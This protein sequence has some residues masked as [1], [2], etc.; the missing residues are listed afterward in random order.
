MD[1]I[2]CNDQ[3]L[4]EVSH[5]ALGRCSVNMQSRLRMDVG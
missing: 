5:Y 3:Q 4:Q 2:L 1:V